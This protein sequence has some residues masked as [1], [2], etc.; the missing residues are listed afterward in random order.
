MLGL[1]RPNRLLVNQAVDLC[2]GVA[3]FSQYL[4]RMLAQLRRQPV[5]AGRARRETRR[6]TRLKEFPL[7]GVIEFPE[8]AD[9]FEVGLLGNVTQRR[10]SGGVPFF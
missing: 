7:A 10:K 4:S 3:H 1:S 9:R 6:R 5:Y 8:Q 2:L